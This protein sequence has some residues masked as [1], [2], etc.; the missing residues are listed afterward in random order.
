MVNQGV[1]PD[2][3]K[4]VAGVATYGRAEMVC[5]TIADLENQNRKPDGIVV[6]PARPE[7]AKG[8]DLASP[9]T[10][11]V[12]SD[13]GLTKQRNAILRKAIEMEADIVMFFDDD[14]IASRDYL[15]NLEKLFVERKS[16]LVATGYLIADGIHGSGYTIEEAK[17]LIA[18]DHA[19]RPN[20]FSDPEKRDGGYG[21]NMAVNL[22]LLEEENL[23]FDEKLP[24]Y[25]W[26]E[27]IDLSARFA[28]A[29]PSGEILFDPRLR[30]VHLGTKSGRVSGV[31]LGYS[32]VVN[33]FYICRKKI[34]PDTRLYR[35][36]GKN[37]IANAIKSFAPEPH[38]DRFGRLRGNLIGLLDIIR[39][40]A[41]PEKIE[42]M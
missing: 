34:M 35:L 20:A 17:A 10:V 31:K 28:K 33:T 32:Q 14:F 22:N 6:C 24:Q 12:S 38:I 1:S 9:D 36:L 18:K 25:G 8:L 4:I 37:F 5:M 29:V 23:W 13:R 26:Q 2:R 40:Q 16:L 30:G 7:D 11:I 15:E 42:R 3:L 19:N 39:G 41:D 27:D 21:C